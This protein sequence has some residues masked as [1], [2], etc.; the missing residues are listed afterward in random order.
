MGSKYASVAVTG[1]NAAPPADDGTQ[2]S[3]NQ[4]KW[5][6]IKDKLA[7]PLNTFASDI[8][9]AL[10]EAFDTSARSVT[11]TSSTLSS[12]NGKTIEIASTVTTSININLGD[13]ATMAAGYIVGVVNR[14]GIAQTIGRVTS[15]DTINGVASN[16]SIPS[17]AAIRLMVNSQANGYTIIGQAQDS[18]PSSSASSSSSTRNYVINGSF[19][20]QQCAIGTTDNSYVCDGWRVLMENANGVVTTFSASSVP[21]G[22]MYR[23]VG[24]VGAGNNGKFGF[25]HPIANGDM[26]ELRSQVISILTS[27]KSTAGISDVRIGLMQ[28]TSTADGISADPI[29]AWNAAG[30]NPTLIANWAFINTPANLSV[31]TSFVDYTVINQSV[32]ATANNLAVFIWCDD[33]TTTTTTDVLE[34]GGYITLCKGA[35][36]PSAQVRS[37]SDEIQLYAPYYQKTFPAA[38][39]PAQ[40]AGLNGSARFSNPAVGAVATMQGFTYPLGKM[41]SAPTVTTYNPSAASVQARDTTSSQNSTLGTVVASTESGFSFSFTAGA[42]SLIVSDWAIHFQ[43]DARL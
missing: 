25:F 24:T 17:L 1:F 16:K 34:I 26:Q 29:S 9:T 35:T 5:A 43:A 33:R 11:T 23:L 21:T 30:T 31:T 28:W 12:D 42:G 14:S 19:K 38:T 39:A 15:A 32:G 3:T 22:A 20:G 37:L 13:A 10:V 4:I 8:D 36:A 27:L 40:N 41:R 2:V 7:D 6:T 18:F